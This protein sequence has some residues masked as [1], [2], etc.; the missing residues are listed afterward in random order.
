MSQ[1]QQ[2]YLSLSEQL[3]K[4]EQPEKAA[5][6]GEM[7]ELLKSAGSKPRPVSLLPAPISRDWKTSTGKKTPE[8]QQAIQNSDEIRQDLERARLHQQELELN[9]PARNPAAG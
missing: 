1:M 9:A 4:V 6:A 8:R 5:Y 7:D 3:A 2:R